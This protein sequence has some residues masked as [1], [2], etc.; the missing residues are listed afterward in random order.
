MRRPCIISNVNAGTPFCAYTSFVGIAE[1]DEFWEVF[2]ENESSSYYHVYAIAD[3]EKEAN[4]IMRILEWQLAQAL[5][6][7]IKVTQAVLNAMWKSAGHCSVIFDVGGVYNS[8][9]GKRA[10]N[11]YELRPV[12]LEDEGGSKYFRYVRDNRL[13][14]GYSLE[15]GDRIQADCPLGLKVLLQF[16]EEGELFDA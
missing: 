1:Q 5:N 14:C 2:I 13:Q 4:A 16:N 11:R 6:P 9:S 12:N 3:T 10:Y 7:P 15:I 8:P